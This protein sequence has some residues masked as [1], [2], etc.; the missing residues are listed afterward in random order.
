MLLDAAKSTGK[1]AASKAEAKV[2]SGL[3]AA[4]HSTAPKVASSLTSAVRSAAPK[5]V[6]RLTSAARNVAPFE[7]SRFHQPVSNSLTQALRPTRGLG[8]AHIGQSFNI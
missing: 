6:S 1:K 2:A 7:L 8:S 4:A 5:A 3:T